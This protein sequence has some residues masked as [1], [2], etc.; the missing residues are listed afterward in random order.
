MNRPV[1]KH[2]T[3]SALPPAPSRFRVPGRGPYVKIGGLL[4]GPTTNYL[5]RTVRRPRYERQ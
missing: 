1:L 3:W 4:V 5:G 2:E